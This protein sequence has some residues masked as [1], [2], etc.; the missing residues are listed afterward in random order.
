MKIYTQLFA[1]LCLFTFS[2]GAQENY[3]IKMAMRMEGLPPEMAAMGEMEITN[4]I[5][6]DKLK[7][8]TLGMMGGRTLLIDGEK[9]TS[10]NDRM[11]NK[12]GYTATRA[13]LEEADKIK[14]NPKPKLNYTS[15][16]KTIAGYECTKVVVTTLRE[17]EEMT[18][19]LWVTDK[20]NIKNNSLMRAQGGKDGLDLSELKGYPLAMEMNQS[21][22]GQNLQM[23]M[24]ATSVSAGP[25]D[26]A[27]F[28]LSTEGYR[29]MTYKEMMSRQ[30]QTGTR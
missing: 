3:T 9:M 24:T 15:E 22:N 28:Q 16:K 20:L 18:S 5:K 6:G 21:M 4:Y 2:A 14:N 10:L 25:I 13:E 23:I 7:S 12:T 11:G 29:M 19:I 27:I 8:E 1:I 26:D 30:S 17:K